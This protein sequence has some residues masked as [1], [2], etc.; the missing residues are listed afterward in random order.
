[1]LCRRPPVPTLRVA[2][3]R[4]DLSHISRPPGTLS[5]GIE[6]QQP[7]DLQGLVIPRKWKTR[8]HCG[9]AKSRFHRPVSPPGAR[10]RSTIAAERCSPRGRI[11]SPARQLQKQHRL[12]PGPQDWEH[13]PSGYKSTPQITAAKSGHRSADPGFH[14]PRPAAGPGRETANLPLPTTAT[15]GPAARPPR[16]GGVSQT[17]TPPEDRSPAASLLPVKNTG[18]KRPAMPATC[19]P[20]GWAKGRMQNAPN[21]TA[22]R[23]EKHHPEKRGK[24]RDLAAKRVGHGGHHHQHQP[25]GIAQGPGQPAPRP[26]TT[27]HTTGR[28]AEAQGGWW[29]TKKPPATGPRAGGFT[30]S[31]PGLVT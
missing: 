13:R 1:M 22:H 26:A 17:V 20:S 3:H 27:T 2:F 28:A 7:T 4:D 16:G 24:A 18:S 15:S 30:S 12:S 6:A 9:K 25:E 29:P 8:F 19:P 23:G 10:S 21:Q 31:E 11:H 5:T 14:S